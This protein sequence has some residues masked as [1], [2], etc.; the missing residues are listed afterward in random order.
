M[1]GIKNTNKTVNIDNIDII[2]TTSML[3][4]WDSYTSIEHYLKML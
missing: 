1:Y 3:K 2:M 4:L